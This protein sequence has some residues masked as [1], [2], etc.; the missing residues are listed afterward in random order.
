MIAKADARGKWVPAAP[1]WLAA[2]YA[3]RCLASDGSKRRLVKWA[4][5]SGR[6]VYTNTGRCVQHI[7]PFGIC[8]E[9]GETLSVSW[10]PG[11]T[12]YTMEVCGRSRM[13]A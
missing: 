5:V 9:R 2:L 12:S 6:A 7:E 10:S 13:C 4:C 3:S 11:E 8:L 1:V